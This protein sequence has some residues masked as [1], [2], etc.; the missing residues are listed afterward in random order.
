MHGTSGYRF[1]TAVNGVLVDHKAADE[2]E[3][4]YRDFADRR[5]AAIAEVR[6]R[7]QDHDHAMR[8]SPRRS[9]MLATELL[10][11]ARADRRTRDYTL[12]H[13]RNA[14]AEFVACFPVY[15][16]YIVDKPSTQDRRYIEWAIAQA[17]RRSRAADT[18]IYEFLRR[19]LLDEPAEDASAELK[20]RVRAFAIKM[21]QFTAPV[22]AKGIEDTAFYR[23]NRLA[24]LNDVA[25]DPSQFG[26]PL[27]GFHGA[28]AE[29]G[30]NRPHTMLA[31]ST[32]DNKRS[33]DVRAR[34]DVLSEMTEDWRKLLRRWDRMNRPKKTTVEGEPAP[35]P[36][37][38]YL[39]YQVLLGTFTAGD[40]TATSK[41]TAS[42]SRPTC[43]RRFAKP[44]CTRAGS[45]RTRI[46]KTR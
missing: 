26:M 41:P 44:R 33:E 7:G 2:M 15:R 17:R 20:E 29:R 5:A 8:R 40:A 35:S 23:Y 12:N 28:C 27:S 21:Q 16:T 45:R 3:R 4:V 9:L 19:V 43:S 1:A 39:L 42:A 11:I 32:H 25:G 38:E 36:N 34:I 14:L 6:L 13:L 10:R 46:T 30:A 24:S 22:T 37:D 31:T 18:T